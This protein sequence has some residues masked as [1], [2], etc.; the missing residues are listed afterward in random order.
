MPFIEGRTV[1]R[2]YHVK[3]T[4]FRVL[5]RRFDTAHA[6]CNTSHLEEI[7]EPC[8]IVLNGDGWQQ[9]YV[10]ICYVVDLVINPCVDLCALGE[11]RR[12]CQKL[13][14]CRS[15][16]RYEFVARDLLEVGDD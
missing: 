3:G 10:N 14:D 2:V 15:S 1:S 8:V 11:L 7:L 9:S 13:V 6:A 5:A 12:I 16:D 4:A